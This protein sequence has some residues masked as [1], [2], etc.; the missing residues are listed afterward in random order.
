MFMTELKSSVRNKIQ[1]FK[2]NDNITQKNEEKIS[3][4]N[5][6][7]YKCIIYHIETQNN[8]NKVKCMNYHI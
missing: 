3:I 1:N 7:I 2:T 4:I 8:S 5:V 6:L